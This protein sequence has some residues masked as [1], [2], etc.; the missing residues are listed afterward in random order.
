[1]GKEYFEKANKLN[2][3][4]KSAHGDQQMTNDI[5]FSDEA[6]IVHI[7]GSRDQSGKVLKV[8]QGLKKCLGWDKQE[9]VG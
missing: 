9:V 8:S 6:V 5:L 2:F 4:A 1:L 3:A 7:S